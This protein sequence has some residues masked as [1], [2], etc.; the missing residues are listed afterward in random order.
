MTT[1]TMTKHFNVDIDNIITDYELAYQHA[2]ESFIDEIKR[3]DEN[4]L[5]VYTQDIDEYSK[6]LKNLSD[7]NNK[8][9]KSRDTLQ[10]ISEKVK[11]EQQILQTENDRLESINNECNSLGVTEIEL[12]D[13][14]NKTKEQLTQVY[15]EKKTSLK[16]L[17]REI[18]SFRAGV[19]MY[20]RFLQLNTN[21]ESNGI[22][23]LI[24][25]TM[26]NVKNHSDYKVIFYEEN[27]NNFKLIDI[28]PRSQ[29]VMKAATLYD[30]N[31][32]IQG[33]LA[34]LYT[35]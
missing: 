17:K 16:K 20:E 8:I 22:N 30:Q 32:D 6:T 11:C 33:L 34:F 21:V 2:K 24:N 1:S 27:D 18:N 9:S 5:K 10:Q 15:K 28:T 35:L 3:T 14:I 12:N 4:I 7:V 19:N 26:K 23:T 29:T 25:I 13:V 31:Q